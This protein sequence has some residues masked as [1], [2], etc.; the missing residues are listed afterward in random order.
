MRANHNPTHAKH[1]TLLRAAVATLV[2]LTLWAGASQAAGP[3]RLFLS[4]GCGWAPCQEMMEIH[5]NKPMETQRTLFP[6]D[7]LNT[8]TLTVQLSEGKAFAT[9]KWQTIPTRG[10]ASRGEETIEISD[11][12]SNDLKLYRLTTGTGNEHDFFLLTA[13]RHPD[14]FKAFLGDDSPVAQDTPATDKLLASQRQGREPTQLPH[15]R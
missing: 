3:G 4:F 2:T 12:E 14:D 9:V 1:F 7:Y 6:G 13:T 5:P 11:L 8:A 15:Y 10:E